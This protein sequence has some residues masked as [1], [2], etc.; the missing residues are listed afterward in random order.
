VKRL[1]EEQRFESQEALV[2]QIRVDCEDAR[3]VLS[4]E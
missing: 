3:R 2:E 4:R 1:R